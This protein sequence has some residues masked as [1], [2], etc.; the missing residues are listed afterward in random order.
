MSQI[1]ESGQYECSGFAASHVVC[2]L[3]ESVHETPIV[4]ALY[5]LTGLIFPRFKNNDF[6][7]ASGSIRT[8]DPRNNYKNYLLQ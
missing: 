6:Q 1:K 8:T 7:Q 2:M 3:Q 4:T 5:H